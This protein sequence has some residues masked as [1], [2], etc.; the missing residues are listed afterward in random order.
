MD[1]AEIEKLK[2]LAEKATRGIWRRSGPTTRG[3]FTFGE[4]EITSLDGLIVVAWSGFDSADGTKAQ[5]R[6]N[7]RFIAYANP[8]RIERLVAAVEGPKD[9]RRKERQ[10]E[11]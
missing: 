11:F 9:T 4:N 10:N 1:K 5:K 7:A 6:L 3:G 8:E 2:G